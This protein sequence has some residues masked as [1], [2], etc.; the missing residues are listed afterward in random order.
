MFKIPIYDVLTKKKFYSLLGDWASLI[1]YDRRS[2]TVFQTGQFYNLFSM[3]NTR[4]NQMNVDECP[5][6]NLLVI[7][8]SVGHYNQTGSA[9]LSTSPGDRKSRTTQIETISLP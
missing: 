3:R 1:E 8:R 6:S 7:V 2:G 9:T 5:V 4:F